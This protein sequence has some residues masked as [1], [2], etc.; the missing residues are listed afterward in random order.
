MSCNKCIT[1]VRI[2]DIPDDIEDSRLQLTYGTQA[3]TIQFNYCPICGKFIE[4]KYNATI[5]S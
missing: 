5:N 4:E 2:N 1:G 3:S